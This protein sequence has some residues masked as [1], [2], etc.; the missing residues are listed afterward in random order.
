MDLMQVVWMA[1]GT[2]QGVG[3]VGSLFTECSDRTIFDAQAAAGTAFAK[4]KA[5]EFAE[6]SLVERQQSLGTGG[7]TTTAAGAAPGID[8]GDAGKNC[9]QRISSI[10]FQVNSA[11]CL[12]MV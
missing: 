4:I 6:A 2:W 7:N 1:A 3:P 9:F 10:C 5:A 8:F 12:L 11:C